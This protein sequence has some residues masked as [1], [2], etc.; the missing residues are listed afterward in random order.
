MM[1]DEG[2]RGPLYAIPGIIH[3]EKK[4]VKGV[5]TLIKRS[6]KPSFKPLKVSATINTFI[7]LNQLQTDFK[8]DSNHL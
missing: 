3:S 2:A 4:N 8:P 1:H 5:A 6:F 7:L